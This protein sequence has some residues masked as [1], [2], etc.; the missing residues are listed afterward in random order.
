VTVQQALRR[1]VALLDENEGHLTATI[2]ENDRDLTAN[3]EVVCAAARQLAT[4]P[5]IRTDD[6][7]DGREWFPYSA[8]SRRD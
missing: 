1:L 8:L 5:E 6:E 2:I 3:R 7:A 4:E